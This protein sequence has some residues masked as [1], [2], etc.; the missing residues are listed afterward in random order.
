MEM[1][2]F[3]KRKVIFTVIITCILYVYITKHSHSNVLLSAVKLRASL[4]E[5]DPESVT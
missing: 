1:T 3:T 2:L 4:Y 5:L